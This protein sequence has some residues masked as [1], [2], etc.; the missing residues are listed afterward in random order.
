MGPP[1]ARAVSMARQITEKCAEPCL[2]LR[3]CAVALSLLVRAAYTPNLAG[4][5]VSAVQLGG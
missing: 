4:A 5:F 1:A 2:S 3:Q